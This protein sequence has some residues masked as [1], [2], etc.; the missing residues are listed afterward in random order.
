MNLHSVAPGDAGLRTGVTAMLDT[1]SAGA[2]TYAAF[3]KHVISRADETIYALVNISQFGVQGHPGIPPFIGDLHDVEYLDPR[4][5]LRCIDAHPER[6]LGVKARLTA[7]L[8]GNREANERVALANAVGVSR[9]SGLLCC[10]HH[11]A[12]AIPLGDVLKELKAGDILT[13]IYHGHGDGGFDPSRDGAP[14]AAL[15]AARERGVVFDVGHGSG[16]F[17]WRVVEPA[18][19]AHGFW[20]DTIS[21]DIHKFNIESPVL[22]LPTTMS[23]FLHLGMPLERVIQCTTSNPAAAMRQQHQLG[24]LLPGRQADITVLQL[25]EGRHPLVDSDCVER[26]ASR[27]LVPVCVFKNGRRFACRV[28]YA[29]ANV[30]IDQETDGILSPVV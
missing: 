18:C 17:A 22:D 14:D 29:A 2:M 16:S 13:H 28:D 25:V 3:E 9:Q 15:V 21:S 7:A 6:L 5:V 26:I 8:A 30:G 1:G 20:P 24:R 10:I 11:V 19:Q 12:S 23:K 27:R 4:P